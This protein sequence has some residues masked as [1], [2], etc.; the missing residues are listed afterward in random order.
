MWY[1]QDTLWKVQDA[2]KAWLSTQP[3]RS[4][5]GDYSIYATDADLR[6]EAVQHL[7]QEGLPGVIDYYKKWT[8]LDNFQLVEMSHVI[9]KALE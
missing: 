7:N 5:Y 8:N 4:V 1:N 3:L 9:K 6:E 2:I